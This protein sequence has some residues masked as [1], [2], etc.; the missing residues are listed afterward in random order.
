[1]TELERCRPWI[2]DALAYSGGTHTFQDVVD[3]IASGH[4]QLWPAPKGCAVT[5]IV[6]YPRKR[7]LHIF[8]AGGE[9]DQLFDGE[10][11]V[12]AWGREQGC[13][14]ITLSGRMGWRRVLEPKGWTTTM[15][16][17]EKDI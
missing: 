1:M 2:E 7:A 13:S 4:M 17:M 10:S 14:M 9:M 3:G 5:Q 16:V 12:T 15:V 8:L 6:V 11:V